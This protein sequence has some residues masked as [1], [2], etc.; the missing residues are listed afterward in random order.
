MSVEIPATVAAMST[1]FDDMPRAMRERYEDTHFRVELIIPMAQAKY[2]R[3]GDDNARL[4]LTE[5]GA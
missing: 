3:L 4:L 5:A 2:V 1:D